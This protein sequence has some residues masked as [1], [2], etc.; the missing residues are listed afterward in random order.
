M[1]KFP[2]I[3]HRFLTDDVVPQLPRRL[4]WHNCPRWHFGL[5]KY[6]CLHKARV[7]QHDCDT[8]V[9]QLHSKTLAD[10]I[11]SGLGRSVRVVT[12]CAVI[13][14]RANTTRDDADLGV[15]RFQNVGQERLGKEEDSKGVNGERPL[16]DL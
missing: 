11:H 4:L 2:R 3:L 6:V 7:Q 5:G 1:P 16:K 13:A 9:L 15:G 8:F 14:Y 12:A 10:R